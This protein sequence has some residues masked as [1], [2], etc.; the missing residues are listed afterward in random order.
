MKA[1]KSWKPKKKKKKK[2]ASPRSNRN[3]KKTGVVRTLGGQG[4][5]QVR[6]TEAPVWENWRE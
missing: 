4:E 6:P 1:L 3:R 2:K 5:N